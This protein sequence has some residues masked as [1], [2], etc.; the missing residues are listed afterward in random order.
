M[1]QKYK[2]TLQFQCVRAIALAIIAGFLSIGTTTVQAELPEY[3]EARGK[4]GVENEKDTN[5]FFPSETVWFNEGAATTVFAKEPEKSESPDVGFYKEKK[6]RP[7]QDP[8]IQQ[9]G[10]QNQNGKPLDATKQPPFDTRKA[11]PDQL[12][13]FYGNPNEESPLTPDEKAPIP[14]KGMMAAMDS[15]NDKLA[16][17]YARQYVRYMRNMSDRVGRTVQLQELAVEREGIRPGNVKDNPYVKL[18]EDD[19]LSAESKKELSVAGLDPK[20]QRMIREAQIEEG[21]QMQDVSNQSNIPVDPKGEVSVLFFFDNSQNASYERAKDIEKLYKKFSQNPN[22]TFS[23]LSGLNLTTSEL[24][25][26]SDKSG[27]SIPVQNG[28]KTFGSMSG[29]SLPAVLLLTKNT[30]KVV[31]VSESSDADEIAMTLKQ[32]MGGK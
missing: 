12:L 24:L 11:S 15:G 2:N 3:R 17:Q 32:M 31:R 20:A 27:I 19:L 10:L 22:V 9:V 7:T 13:A 1:E 28:G 21:S 16:Y 30:N 25:S 5:G 8:L 14:F 18:L 26:F 6:D 23:A 4:D 29:G